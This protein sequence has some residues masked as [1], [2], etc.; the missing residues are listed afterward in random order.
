MTVRRSAMGKKHVCC[1]LVFGHSSL[2][3]TSNYSS[4]KEAHSPAKSRDKMITRLCQENTRYGP[5]RLLSLCHMRCRMVG[6]NFVSLLWLVLLCLVA[7]FD[8]CCVGVA[9]FILCGDLFCVVVARFDL[10]CVAVACFVV[11]GGLFCVVWWLFFCVGLS[12][13]VLTFTLFFF[14]F[15]SLCCAGLYCCVIQYGSG[16][17]GLISELHWK[18]GFCHSVLLCFTLNL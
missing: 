5:E 1:A 4:L 11:C 10:C 16:L 17:F 14:F 15:S 3:H 12:C 6:R 7:R 18:G 13:S 9:C 8:L 2:L